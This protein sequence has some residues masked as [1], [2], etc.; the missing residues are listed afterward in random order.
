MA[1]APTDCFDRKPCDAAA[2]PGGYPVP[3]IN[4]VM[5]GREWAILLFLGLI[6]GSSFLFIKVAVLDVPPLTFVWLRVMIAA[7]ALWLFLRIRGI[8][9]SLPREVLLSMAVLALLNNVLPFILFAWGQARIATGLGAILNAT[10]P[11][12]GVVVAHFLTRDEPLT[13][14]RLAGVVLG[15]GGVA[16]MIGPGLLSELGDQLAAQLACLAAALSYAFAGIF[17]RRFK[18]LG[19]PATTVT[20]GQL[21]MSAIMMLPL[22]LVVETP[23]LQPLP[24]AA[25]IGSILALALVCTAFAYVLYFQ[26]IETAGATNALLV[27]LLTPPTAILLGGLFLGELLALRDFAGLALIALAFAAIDGRLLKRLRLSASCSA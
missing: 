8:A 26:L 21:T 14:A 1:I 11:I 25:A 16:L 9:A 6:W 13:P 5:N 3:M 17:A 27:P 2:P 4:R 10:T 22:A 24:S 23:W 12:W 18:R 19:I 7:A 15:F 20:A